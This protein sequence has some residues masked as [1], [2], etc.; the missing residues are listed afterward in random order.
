MNVESLV[1]ASLPID[2][3]KNFYSQFDDTAKKTLLAYIQFYE[4]QKMVNKS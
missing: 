4:S 3:V 2:S 1:A